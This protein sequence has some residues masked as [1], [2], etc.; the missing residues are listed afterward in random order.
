[1][2]VAGGEESIAG[3]ERRLE[4]ALPKGVEVDTPQGKSD[5]IE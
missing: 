4:R 1:M 3:V 5:D 2:I